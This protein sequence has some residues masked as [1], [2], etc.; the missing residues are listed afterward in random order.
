MQRLGFIDE[1]FLRHRLKSTSAGG[2]AGVVVA[3][4]LFIFQIY[5]DHVTRWDLFAVGVVAVVVKFS[6]LIWHRIYD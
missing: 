2:I 4:A 6:V 3:M 5:H 1:R